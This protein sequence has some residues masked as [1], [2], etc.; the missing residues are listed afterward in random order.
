[1]AHLKETECCGIRELDGIMSDND[2]RKSVVDAAEQWHEE[3][4]DGAFVFF[5]SFGSSTA[6]QNIAAYIE[7][8]KLG[9]VMKTR[10]TLNPNSGNVLT[11]WVWTVNKRNFRRF[12][13]KTK[14]YKE[15]YAEGEVWG[16]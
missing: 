14:R 6:G 12:W 16:D 3:D 11:M 13:R 15:N 1:M 7:K 5:S 8:Y 9:T 2:A 10:P 4:V